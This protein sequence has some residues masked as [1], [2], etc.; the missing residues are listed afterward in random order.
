VVP[1]VC[2]P[3]MDPVCPVSLPP[4]H[5][6]QLTSPS[7]SELRELKCS[8]VRFGLHNSTG[9]AQTTVTLTFRKTNQSDPTKGAS[10][11]G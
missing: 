10:H 11:R 4:A 5:G 7:T 1:G 6:R 8:E 3:G 2:D 9:K